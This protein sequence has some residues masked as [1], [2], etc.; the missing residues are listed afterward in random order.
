MTDKVSVPARGC[1]QPQIGGLYLSIET[2]VNGVPLSTFFLDPT[3]PLHPMISAQVPNRGMAAID[4]GEVNDK[5]QKIYHIFD[6]IGEDHYPNVWDWIKETE[7]LGF[8]RKISPTFPFDLITPETMYFPVHSKAGLVDPMVFKN[9]YIHPA[10]LVEECKIPHKETDTCINFL[11]NDLIGPE[12]EDQDMDER[13]IIIQMP[14]FAYMGYRSPIE[15]QEEYIR[16]AFMRI[17]IGMMGNFKYYSDDTKDV[18][19]KQEKISPKLPKF[20]PLEVEH[21]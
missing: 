16:S 17:P 9:F 2:A 10:Q 15:G 19:E 13:K 7:L 3:L 4:S 14:S 6:H 18:I 8:H 21:V 1:G 11:T 20:M 12:D 5:G